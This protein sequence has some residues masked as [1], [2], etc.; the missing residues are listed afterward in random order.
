[1]DVTGAMPGLYLATPNAFLPG[2]PVSYVTTSTTY[3]AVSSGNICTGSFTAPSSGAVLVR[4]SGVYITLSSDSDYFGFQLAKSGTTNAVGYQGV[5]KISVNGNAFPLE[6]MEFLVTG[7]GSGSFNFD[8]MFAVSG[9]GT[10]T[11]FTSAEAAG[12]TLA[13]S[14][15]DVGSPIIMSVQ[16]A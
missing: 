11:V 15:L 10:L 13:S 16:A 9:G 7:L 12:T 2:S 14:V 3:A 5:S 6:V 8:L 4:V 1:M